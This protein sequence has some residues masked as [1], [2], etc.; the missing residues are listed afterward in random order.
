MTLLPGLLIE[1]LVNGSIALIWL[2]PVF[3]EF[4]PMLSEPLLP[5]LI[6]AL[7]VTG[8][9]IDVSAWTITWPVK[10]LVRKAVHQKY[11]GNGDPS[12]ASGTKRLAKIILYA[13]ELSREFAMRS[14]RDRVA[15]G[16]IVNAL[17]CAILIFPWWA[18]LPAVIVSISVWIIFEKL[19]YT[20]ELCAEEILDGKLQGTKVL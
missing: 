15:R 14:S 11:R 5:L 2:H 6:A 4:M 12:S 13:P 16:T 20:F 17:M 10:G 1:Y 9:L 18:G 8:M 7:Y 19:S 3:A